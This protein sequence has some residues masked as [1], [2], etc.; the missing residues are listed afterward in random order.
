M[1]IADEMVVAVEYEL[2]DQETKEVLDSNMG[3]KPLEFILGKGMIIPGLEEHIRGMNDGEKSEVTIPPESAYGEYSE[4]K[5]EKLPREQFAGI[6]LQAGMPLYGRA[7]DGST[8]QVRVD[9]FTEEEVTIDY[10]HPL[11]GRSLNFNLSVVGV[12]EMNPH[13]KQ[14]GHLCSDHQAGGCCGDGDCEG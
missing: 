2:R 5:L 7:A 9:S 3:M 1:S 10:N 14:T 13:E 6:E 12:R 11:A 8:V 4:A